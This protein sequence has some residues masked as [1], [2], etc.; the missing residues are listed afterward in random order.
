[1]IL[2]IKL[3]RRLNSWPRLSEFADLTTM[4]DRIINHEQLMSR[5]GFTSA[6]QL[7]RKTDLANALQAEGCTL[8]NDS[9]FCEAYISG[10]SYASLQEVVASMKVLKVYKSIVLRAEGLGRMDAVMSGGDCG[11]GISRSSS[12]SSIGTSQQQWRGW[13]DCA[14]QIIADHSLYAYKRLG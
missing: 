12:V 3:M 10:D 5:G 9:R 2:V 4:I 8:R 14:N 13:I 7:Q 6:V 1:M 11:D